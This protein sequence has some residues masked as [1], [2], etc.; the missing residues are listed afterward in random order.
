MLTY[1][2]ESSLTTQLFCVGNIGNNSCNGS[3]ACRTAEGELNLNK[4]INADI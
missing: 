4:L 2:T 3:S 1:Q